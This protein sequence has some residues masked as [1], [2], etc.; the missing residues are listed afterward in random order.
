M[1]KKLIVA[2]IIFIEKGGDMISC[3]LIIPFDSMS[4]RFFSFVKLN[5][6]QNEKKDT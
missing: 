3:F 4:S 2:I 5:F 1:I 6:F